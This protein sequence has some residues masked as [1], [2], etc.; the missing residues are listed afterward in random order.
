MTIGLSI[1]VRWAKNDDGDDVV[2]L[3]VSTRWQRLFY[4]LVGGLAVV[5]IALASLRNAESKRQTEQL[6]AITRSHQQ[7]V[8]KQTVCNQ[9]LIRAINANAAIAAADRA[10]LDDLLGSVGEV[11]LHGNGDREA[12]AA[13]LRAAFTRYDQQREANAAAREPYPPPDCGQ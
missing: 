12:R 3:G 6:A 5:S 4:L 10:N 1:S 7:I 9:D 11:V 13:A 2:Q 8:S